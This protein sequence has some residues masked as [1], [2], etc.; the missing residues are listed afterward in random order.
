[1]T[2]I[3]RAVNNGWILTIPPKELDQSAPFGDFVYANLREVAT[4]LAEIHGEPM[5]TVLVRGR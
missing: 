4:K 2:Y 3:L 1:M 5:P